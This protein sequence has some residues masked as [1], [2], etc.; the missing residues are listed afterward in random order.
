[1]RC[2][3]WS[4][5]SRCK[6]GGNRRQRAINSAHT[7]RNRWASSRQSL[8]LADCRQRQLSCSIMLCARNATAP[9]AAAPLSVP[10]TGVSMQSRRRARLWLNATLSLPHARL[11]HTGEPAS[12]LNTDVSPLASARVR[13]GQRCPDMRQAL[14]VV[15]LNKFDHFFPHVAAQIPGG[16]RILCRH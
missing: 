11:P 8:S 12:C 10:E 15:L 5:H 6:K 16:G 3:A 1:M 7:A 2:A 14:R 9:H 13:P 4:R